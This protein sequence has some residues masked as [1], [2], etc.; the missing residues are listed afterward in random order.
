MTKLIRTDA[1]HIDF[2]DLVAQLDEE[3]KVIDGD[4]HDFYNK[5][6]HIDKIKYA[7]VAY[8]NDTPIGC[9][10]IKHLSEGAMEVKRMYTHQSA[11]CKG[12]ATKILVELEKWSKELGYDKCM[13]ETG[14][15]QEDAIALYTKQQYK[16]IP[17]YGQYAGVKN[18]VCFEKVL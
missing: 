16:V 11:R 13:L 18:S 8:F 6:N 15:K 9:G 7:V 1:A 12:I 2:I 17:N 3:L 14:I 4:D 5:F 10:A